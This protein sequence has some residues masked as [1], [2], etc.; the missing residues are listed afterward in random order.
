MNSIKW[1]LLATGITL[2]QKEEKAITKPIITHN[3]HWKITQAFY[4]IKTF[5]KP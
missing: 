4:T 3:S 2:P 5:L 1:R